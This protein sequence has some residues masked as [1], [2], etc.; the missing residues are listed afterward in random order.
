M[1]KQLINAVSQSSYKYAETSELDFFRG[2]TCVHVYNTQIFWQTCD[3]NKSIKIWQKVI[4][5]RIFVQI[6]FE[7]WK[8]EFTW[9]YILEFLAQTFLHLFCYCWQNSPSN[10]RYTSV[11]TVCIW[12][13]EHARFCVEFFLCAIYKFSFIHSYYYWRKTSETKW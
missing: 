7:T 9:F 1:N 5:R 6:T 2:Y 3:S 11:C 12:R 13:C 4:L 10:K 8:R